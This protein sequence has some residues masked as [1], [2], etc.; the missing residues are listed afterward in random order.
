MIE[1]KFQRAAEYLEAG[2]EPIRKTGLKVVD[3]EGNKAKLMIPI[4]GNANH[5]GIMYA[6][7]LFTIGEVA[8]GAAYAASIDIYKY[9]IVVKSINI[10]FRKPAFTDV[11]VVSGM[12]PAK[13]AVIEK[14]ASEKGKADYDLAITL[15]DDSGNMVAELQGI[16]QLRPIPEGMKFPWMD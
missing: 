14:E 5:V 12:D 7:V 16:W 4:E 11:Y 6:G 1:P 2:M 8:G 15:T 3:L 13:V 9:F 10:Q